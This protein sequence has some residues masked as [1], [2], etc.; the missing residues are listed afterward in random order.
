MM[1]QKEKFVSRVVK[2]NLIYS[3]LIGVTSVKFASK[4][5]AKNAYET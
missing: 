2:Q 5:Y 1:Y 3:I 4:K